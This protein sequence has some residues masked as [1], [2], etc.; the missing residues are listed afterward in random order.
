MS[1]RNIA[2]ARNR[3]VK[4]L[5]EAIAHARWQEL[6]DD[7]GWLFASELQD[8]D[9]EETSKLVRHVDKMAKGSADLPCVLERESVNLIGQEG[10]VKGSADVRCV[11]GRESANLIELEE[12]AK[13][14]CDEQCARYNEMERV[15]HLEQTASK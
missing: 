8:A 5:A 15:N 13:V 2:P 11:L 4:R 14:I 7:L 10:I 1:R 3:R 9:I 12:E 6:I